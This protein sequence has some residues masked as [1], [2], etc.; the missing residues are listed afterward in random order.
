MS[1]KT[2]SFSSFGA[3]KYATCITLG[4]R[5]LVVENLHKILVEIWNAM[6]K[7]K[8]KRPGSLCCSTY[9]HLHSQE[10]S[11]EILFDS[12]TNKSTTN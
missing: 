3:Q 11:P 5:A 2:F 8:S 4:R 1:K 6:E 10:P 12:Q 9:F 7:W